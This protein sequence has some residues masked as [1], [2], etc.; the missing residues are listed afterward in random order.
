MPCQRL[1]SKPGIQLEESPLLLTPTSSVSAIRPSSSAVMPLARCPSPS[2]AACFVGGGEQLAWLAPCAWRGPPPLLLPNHR[3]TA[4]AAQ[5]VG[6]CSSLLR[7]ADTALKKSSP[8][9]GRV[10]PPA[11]LPP[12]HP[13]ALLSSVGDVP[14]QW[15]RLGRQSNLEAASPTLGAQT[16]PKLVLRMR[17]TL[18]FLQIYILQRD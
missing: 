9:A 6:L 2:D 5:H 18:L 15:A 14:T 1:R 17:D 8:Y 3:A 7:T 11:C 10:P 13:A 12:I 16:W 4:T